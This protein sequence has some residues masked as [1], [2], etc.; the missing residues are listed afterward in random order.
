MEMGIS[1]LSEVLSVPDLNEFL[2]WVNQGKNRHVKIDLSTGKDPSI[3]V[4]EYKE[5]ILDYTCQVVKSVSEINLEELAKQRELKELAR[6]K[7]K[8]PEAS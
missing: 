2:E 8:Y 5:S 7:E 6:L 3:T 1:Q 4:G